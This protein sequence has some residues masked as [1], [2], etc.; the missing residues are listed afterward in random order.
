MVLTTSAILARS[1]S[2]TSEAAALKEPR[3]LALDDPGAEP[4]RGRAGRWRDPGAD[5][6]RLAFLQYTSGSTAAPKGVMVSHRN[7][8]HNQEAIR[9]AFGQ[10]ESSVIVGWLPLF[11]D[12]GL[13]GNVLA[14]PL[15]RRTLRADV[16]RRLSR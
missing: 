5:P 3:W 4:A 16:P 7:L 12:M 1:G 8:L 10:S 13:V 15:R 11:H 9:R 6:D 14:A 2:W